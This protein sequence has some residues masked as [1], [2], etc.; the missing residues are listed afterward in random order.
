MISLQ[1]IYLMSLSGSSAVVLFASY[2]HLPHLQPV[3]E[4]ICK[5]NK[6][7]EWFLTK[8]N[9]I[10]IC[11][12][13]NGLPK[14]VGLRSHQQLVL[15]RF[16]CLNCSKMPKNQCGLTNCSYFLL[17]YQLI[18]NCPP[19]VKSMFP[20]FCIGTRSLLCLR[21]TAPSKVNCLHF[22]CS[23]SFLSPKYFLD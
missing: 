1:T 12:L 9:Q 7:L 14:D 2:K 22:E 4:W 15:P 17:V 8:G 20:D 16:S 10:L 11:H 13:Q 21:I 18:I 23:L 5:V 19:S 6:N 3:S